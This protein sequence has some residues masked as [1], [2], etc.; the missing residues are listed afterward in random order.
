[1]EELIIQT[2]GQTGVV[3]L[4]VIAFFILIIWMF[5][6][7]AKREERLRDDNKEIREESKIR[8][9]KLY[10]V[11][12]VISKDLPVIKEELGKINSKISQLK[13]EIRK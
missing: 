5:K 1:M 4:V 9:E 6:E 2:Y 12:E 10:L 13:E 7:N 3:G 8:E 11:I